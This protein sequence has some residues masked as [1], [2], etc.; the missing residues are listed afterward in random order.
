ML[1]S[2]SDRIK[3]FENVIKHYEEKGQ[4]LPAQ[5]AENL[6]FHQ[7]E[8]AAIDKIRAHY[9]PNKKENKKGHTPVVGQV[10]ISFMIQQS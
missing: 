2:E 7:R 1:W 10:M 4:Q 3:H 9:W 5:F 8:K 6:E